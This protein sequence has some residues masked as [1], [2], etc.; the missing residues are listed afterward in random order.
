VAKALVFQL[1]KNSNLNIRV[2]AANAPGNW[3]TS[4]EVPV[5]QEAVENGEPSI[6]N[7]AQRSLKKINSRPPTK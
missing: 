3:G 6:R 1:K 5:L 2:L 7:A 4:A